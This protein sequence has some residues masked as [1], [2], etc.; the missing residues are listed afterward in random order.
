[1]AARGVHPT[2]PGEDE[3]DEIRRHRRCTIP[4]PIHPNPTTS[5]SMDIALR[6]IAPPAPAQA[7]LAQLV[8]FAPPETLPGTASLHPDTHIHTRYPRWIP[9]PFSDTTPSHHNSVLSSFPL[10]FHLCSGIT[11]NTPGAFLPRQRNGMVRQQ[12]QR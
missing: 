8:R 11:N 10:G 2:L 7:T 12:S 6:H 4:S 9:T 5:I 1:M 3:R